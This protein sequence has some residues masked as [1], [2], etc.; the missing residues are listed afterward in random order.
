MRTIVAALIH[1]LAG[2]FNVAIVVMI[3]WMMFA[4]LAVNL[5]GGKL[6]YCTLGTYSNQTREECLRNHGE[7]KIQIFNYD[8]VPQAMITLFTIATMEN[9]PDYMYNAI[10]I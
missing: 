7:W 4:I 8:S 10:N 2:I 9:W 6:N 1:S 5:F 3:V